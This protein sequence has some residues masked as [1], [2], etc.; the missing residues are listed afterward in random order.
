MKGAE[1]WTPE[2]Q[3]HLQHPAPPGRRGG[4]AAPE[5]STDCAD[6]ILGGPTGA[7][8]AAAAAAAAPSPPLPPGASPTAPLA[9]VDATRAGMTVSSCAAEP[10]DP[11]LD[12]AT[13]AEST[14]GRS[15][16]LLKLGGGRR[17]SAALL[18]GYACSGRPSSLFAA[19]PRVGAGCP[20]GTLQHADGHAVNAGG[21]LRSAAPGVLAVPSPT[22]ALPSPLR[23][24]PAPPCLAAPSSAEAVFGPGATPDV[25]AV[26]LPSELAQGLVRQAARWASEVAALACGPGAL[27][28]ACAEVASHYDVPGKAGSLGAG[29]NL[30]LGAGSG[31]HCVP[32]DA[33]AGHSCGVDMR[34]EATGAAQAPPACSLAAEGAGEQRGAL[35][36][37]SRA[38]CGEG[39]AEQGECTVS[40]GGAPG[41]CSSCSAAPPR[42]S[43]LPEPR[44]PPVDAALSGK[45]PCDA[46]ASSS[47]S[48]GLGGVGLGSPAATADDAWTD[49]AAAARRTTSASD[50][51][52]WVDLAAAAAESAPG[53]RDAGAWRDLLEAVGASGAPAHGAGG[54]RASGG[55]AGAW[56][57]GEDAW[58]E[59]AALSSRGSNGSGAGG[60]D[61][62]LRAASPAAPS[63]L[64]AAHASVQGACAAADRRNAPGRE[65]ADAEVQLMYASLGSAPAEVSDA[66]GAS[67]HS[68]PGADP[69]RV[70]GVADGAA[71]GLALECTVPAAPHGGLNTHGALMGLPLPRPTPGP[72]RGAATPR[73]APAG[74]RSG[75]RMA[76]TPDAR[77]LDAGPSARARW[78]SLD[79]LPLARQP[80]PRSQPAAWEAGASAAAGARRPS[81]A[82]ADAARAGA[83]GAPHRPG[84]VADMGEASGC[85]PRAPPWAPAAAGSACAEAKEHAE[86]SGNRIVS[87]MTGARPVV[88]A[89]GCRA[90][91]SSA[92]I[93]ASAGSR[94]AGHEEA[95]AALCELSAPAPCPHTAA[96]SRAGSTGA[97]SGA[98]R[99]SE[100][101]P[102][103]PAEA[104]A[105]GCA[106]QPASGRA[107]AS[108]LVYDPILGVFFDT[109]SGQLVGAEA[110]PVGGA[111]AGEG[112]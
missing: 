101:A 24:A 30:D 8:V 92:A 99:A 11:G 90:R 88:R 103:L 102:L 100:A 89:T 27:P 18:R 83:Y 2:P 13:A 28:G 98:E 67:V 105:A 93:T 9:P 33:T 46:R 78:A 41:S 76:Q 37:A 71:A 53:A 43:L 75:A 48:E 68:A 34:S 39:G 59:L 91:A 108:A 19:V 66:A 20:P 7:S 87:D 36:Q 111:G 70:A 51:D 14:G 52:A 107:E 1:V 47:C 95:E 74:S 32:D 64:A 79:D 4:S 12:P 54:G 6:A 25:A 5:P 31:T 57:E 69:E 65:G 10:S 80:L 96:G 63:S 40:S 104:G 56:V 86:A 55:A 35:A 61:A 23:A 42:A 22:L 84:C 21:A 112:V 45:L 110:L 26:K 106:A 49:L 50:A 29:A 97:P 44:E 60:R 38:A 62:D 72:E 77:G 85:A 73:T 82:G 94:Y 15:R 16:A 17:R 81:T 109:A 3:T 58:T